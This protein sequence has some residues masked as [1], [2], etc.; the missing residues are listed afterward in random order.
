M[1]YA[2]D[3]QFGRFNAGVLD[4]AIGAKNENWSL[5]DFLRSL[6]STA[7]V[8]AAVE[9]LEP[10]FPGYRRTE[11]ALA[12]YRDLLRGGEEAPLPAT[13]SRVEP[14]GVYAGANRLAHR[15][16]RLGDLRVDAAMNANPTVY[17]GALVD[18]VRRFQARHAL[19]PNGRL[20]QA[21]IAQLNVPLTAR[22]RQLEFSLERWRWAPH[23]FA[24]PPIVVNIPEFRLRALN[25]EYRTEL[26][27]K[28]VTGKAYGHQTPVFTADLRNI[29]FHPYWDVPRSIERNELLPKIERDPGYLARNDYEVVDAAG[30]AAMPD[31]VDDEMLAK[32]RSGDARIRQAP[33]AKNA[34]GAV[35]FLFPNEHNVYLHGTP[36]TGLFART[37][38]DF[39]HGCIRVEEPEKL[40]VWVLRDERGWT[41]DRVHAAMNGDNTQEVKLAQPIPVLIVYATAVVLETGETL[42][43]PDIYGQDAQLEALARQGYPYPKWHPR[44]A[45]TQ[46]T[47]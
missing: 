29:I 15:L 10:P 6:S 46:P 32:I 11:L 5:P 19:E 28:V 27:M 21:T 13:K 30:K 18:A 17:D 40:A 42:F 26:T 31:A 39:S 36:E 12:R 47:D 1:R 23:G 45:Q 3:L 20:T 37:R 41:P 8:A 2:A 25:G 33:G 9:S 24:R 14:G 7:N 4:T 22:I 44:L 38:R 16:Q 35:K 43:F 34:L